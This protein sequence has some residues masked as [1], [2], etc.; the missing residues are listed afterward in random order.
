MD[1]S[2]SM[3]VLRTRL[4]YHSWARWGIGRDRTGLRNPSGLIS[5]AALLVILEQQWQIEIAQDPVFV[6]AKVISGAVR[7]SLTINIGCHT[8][9]YRRAAGADVSGF[10]NPAGAN[11]DLLAFPKP[12]ALFCPQRYV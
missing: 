9:V 3:Q 10:G 6:G 5:C 12:P 7:A 1:V 8:R 2:L 4:F 11:R